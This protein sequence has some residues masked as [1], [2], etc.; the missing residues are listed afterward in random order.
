M[1]VLRWSVRVPDT[2]E[3]DFV[4]LQCGANRNEKGLIHQ[5]EKNWHTLKHFHIVSYCGS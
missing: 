5:A 2:Q 4:H 3:E 1:T